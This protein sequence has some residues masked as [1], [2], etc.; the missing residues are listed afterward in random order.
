LLALCRARANLEEGIIAMSAGT[1][2]ETTWK[3]DTTHST[4]EFAVKHMMF[5]TVK[6]RFTDVSGTLD[7]DEEQPLDG[8]AD[9]RIGAGSIDTGE[10]QRDA[11]LKSADFFDVEKF[12]TLTFRSTKLEGTSE[13]FRMT[14]DLTIHGVTRPITLQVTHEGRGKDPWGSERIGYSATGTLNRSD[15]GLLWNAALE[16][17]GFLV[18]DEVKINLELELVKQ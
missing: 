5:T 9:I 3:L 15:F 2:T 16:T 14:G 10:A 13:R 12:P 11:H 18:G 17:G 4:V 6:G 1:Q 8:R 7:F